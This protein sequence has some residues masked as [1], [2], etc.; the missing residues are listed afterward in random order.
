M[1]KLSGLCRAGLCLGIVTTFANA[2]PPD[3]QTRYEFTQIVMGV[4][5]RLVFFADNP[6]DAHDAARAAFARLNELDGV[7]SDYRNDSELVHLCRSEP[8]EPVTVSEDLC[9]VL[10]LA[11]DISRR[12]DGAYDCTV[13]PMVR[14]WRKARKDGQLPD[15]AAIQAARELVGP[16]VFE[17]DAPARKVTVSQAGA[18][19]DLGGIGKGFAAD[20]AIRTLATL[21]ITAALVDLGGDVSVSAP[22]PGRN[23]WV[24][25]VDDGNQQ[26]YKIHLAHGAIATSGDLEQHVIIE[27]GRYSHIVHPRTGMA[28]KSVA[29]ATVL[30]RTGAEADALASAACVLGPSACDLISSRFP[31]VECAVAWVEEEPSSQA[32]QTVHSNRTQGFPGDG[33]L[34]TP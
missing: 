20:E 16:G 13:G 5:A 31:G 29:S 4:S 28:L 22:P 6:Q 33:E 8:G 26:P 24:V 30:A 21:G 23:G 3:E 25:V 12:T 27:G 15:P 34:W 14:L 19:I 1:N 18:A 7:M 17:I 2:G 32:T 11:Q 10:T 9:R